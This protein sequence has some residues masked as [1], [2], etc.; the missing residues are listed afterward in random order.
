MSFRRLAWL[1]PAALLVASFVLLPFATTAA[2]PQLSANVT[3]PTGPE[4]DVKF[5]DGSTLKVKLL[6]ET[7]DL[8]TKHGTLKIA[9]A[10]IKK[11]DFATRIDRKSVV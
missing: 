2:P 9:T 4:I 8:V 1:A 10:D 11:I 5:I 7:V 6:D 3:G